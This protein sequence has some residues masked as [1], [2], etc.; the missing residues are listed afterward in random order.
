LLAWCSLVGVVLFWYEC[1]SGIV[2]W[3]LLRCGRVVGVLRC[4][5][6]KSV[7]VFWFW[8]SRVGVQGSA[9]ARNES[10]FVKC[11]MS[12]GRLSLYILACFFF[13]FFF[14]KD[15]VCNDLKVH[16]LRR[17]A[18]RAICYFIW[19]RLWWS[20]G[21]SLFPAQTCCLFGWWLEAQ[22][23]SFS[24]NAVLSKFPTVLIPQLGLQQCWRCVKFFVLSLCF[25]M[26]SNLFN[27]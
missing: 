21:E 10:T 22:V 14:C 5:G 4:V 9:L 23:W 15:F 6:W 12:C 20:G 26:R 24:F 3:R 2:A 19:T 16:F 11:V 25:W 8:H 17:D 1:C 13:F 7:V 27:A 18:P